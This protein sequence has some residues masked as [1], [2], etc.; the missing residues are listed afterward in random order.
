MLFFAPAT[1]VA[2]AASRGPWSLR[3]EVS[4]SE[5]AKGELL[6]LCSSSR[7]GRDEAMRQA[8]EDKICEIEA[9]NPT[10]N[11]LD[12]PELLTACWRLVYTTS[13]SILGSRRP[14]PFRPRPRI[15]QSIDAFALAAKNEEWV[16]MGL[17]RNTVLA[18]LEPRDDKQTVDVQFKYFGIGWFRIP[19]PKSA[20]GFLNTTF[21]DDTMRIAR[22]DKGNTFVLVREQGPPRL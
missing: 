5:H 15:L 18:S 7:M 13:D 14:R 21:L 1:F 8:V 19:A 10:P 4:S 2:L 16:L 6:E 9:W 20:R 11:P 3:A 17:L 12:S 22:G